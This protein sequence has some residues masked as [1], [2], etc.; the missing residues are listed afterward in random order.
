VTALERWLKRREPGFAPN[1]Q[2]TSTDGYF[3]LGRSFACSTAPKV[4]GLTP[5]LDLVVEKLDDN[6]ISELVRILR[7]GSADEQRKMIDKVSD[8]AINKN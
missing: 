1:W 7:Y 3:V 6:E 4:T 2:H 5:V 8:D